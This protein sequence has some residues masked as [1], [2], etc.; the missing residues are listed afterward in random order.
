MSSPVTICEDC[1]SFFAKAP[2]VRLCATCV[3]GSATVELAPTRSDAPP[4]P[5]D[6]AALLPGHDVLEVIATGGMGAVHRARQDSLER[7]VAVKIIRAE[8]ASAEDTERFLR[9]ARVLAQLDHPNIVP[10]YDAGTDAEGR[11]FYTM[12]MVRGRTLKAIILAVCKGT[13]DGALER[14]LEIFRKVCDAVAFA[15]SRGV[16]H[17][18]LK[19]DNVMVGE[20]GEVLVMDWGL[21][22]ELKNGAHFSAPRATATVES[23]RGRALETDLGLTMDGIVL[24]TPQ[25]MA[26]EQANGCT[27]LDARCDVYALGGILYSILTLRPAVRMGTLHEMLDSVRTGRLEPVTFAPQLFSSPKARWHIPPALAA[28]VRQAMALDREERFPTVTALAA[29]VDAHLAGYATSAEHLGLAGQLWLLINRHRTVSI[30]ALVLLAVSAGFVVRLIDSEQRATLSAD[31]ARHKEDAARAAEALAQDSEAATRRAL[32][33]SNIAL[34]DSAYAANDSGQMRAALAVVPEELRDTNW[35]YLHARTDERQALIEWEKNSFLIGSV[36]HPGRPGVFTAA[37]PADKLAVQTRIITFEAKTGKV[38]GEFPNER[39]GWVRG[40]VYS[41]DGRFLAVGR[42][43]DVGISIHNPEDGSELLYWPTSWV[44]SLAFLPDGKRLLQSAGASVGC[45]LWEAGTGRE[46]W[47]LRFGGAH[48]LVPDGSR[49]ACVAE[50]E[51]RLL[52]ADDGRELARYPLPGSLPLTAS[53]S[54][55]GELLIVALTNGQIRGVRLADGGTA[56]EVPGGETGSIVRTAF[57]SDGRRFVTVATLNDTTQSVQVRD[58]AT[59]RVLRQL[60]G[61]LGGVE[62]LCIHPLSGDLLIAGARSATWALP[63]PRAPGW[64]LVSSMSTARSEGRAMGGFLGGDDL[65]LSYTED[66]DTAAIDL[67]SD[68]VRWKPA[69]RSSEF[70]ATSADGLTGVIQTEPLETGF[71]FTIVRA[72]S[73]ALRETATVSFHADPYAIGLSHDGSRLALS[74]AW[75]GIAT[76]LSTGKPLPSV[77]DREMSVTSTYGLAWHGTDPARLIGIFTRFG[78]RGF[79]KSENWIISWDTDTGACTAK[80]RTT[81]AANCLATEPGGTRLAEAGDDKLVRIRDATTLAELTKFRAHDGPINALAWNPARPI[82]ATGSADRSVRLWNAET[83]E[84]LEELH[85]GMREP[86]AL[87]FSPSGR[88]LA[89]V[90]PGEKTLVWELDEPGSVTAK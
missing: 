53:L 80:L 77:G 20:F 2:G 44:Q 52:A 14:L 69:K 28:V 1:G 74:G 57:T 58:S 25:Y 54:P 11:C 33:Q 8:R 61:G 34:A 68:Q 42:I 39:R 90:I 30:A 26:P 82:I 71:N 37:T 7:D 22:G 48:L 70:S 16:I 41:P 81:A 46:I 63:Q 9:E 10:I 18:D 17:R 51:L 3:V 43:M 40:L 13:E 65:F 31:I 15:H 64:R 75:A 73:T 56:F 50:M 29:D 88:R 5:P 66:R 19:P 23:P 38:L 4:R 45:T 83:G 49:V 86:S 32:A 24:G 6:E 12:K 35:Q 27:D 59:G 84:L 87:Y 89:C 36:P 78:R 85:I 79:E 55:D 21:A 62:S 76:Y 47:S 67:G 72:D 60:R